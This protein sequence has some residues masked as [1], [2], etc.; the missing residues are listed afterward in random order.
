[1]QPM[2]DEERLARLQLAPHDRA[3]GVDEREAVAV[4]PL[5]V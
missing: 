4:E 5:H 2:A 1:M 3:A